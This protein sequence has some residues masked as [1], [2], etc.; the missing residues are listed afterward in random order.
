MYREWTEIQCWLFVMFWNF[1]ILHPRFCTAVWAWVLYVESLWFGVHWILLIFWTTGAW[2]WVINLTILRS[3]PLIDSIQINKKRS[4]QVSIFHVKKIY[5]VA[6]ILQNLLI[7]GHCLIMVAV[8]VISI[9]LITLF[10]F[11][12]FTTVIFVEQTMQIDQ[13]DLMMDNLNKM[14]IMGRESI[15]L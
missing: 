6:R 4:C 10:S 1:I 7:L 3:N 9:V 14:K 5:L 13:D 11:L 8:P 2:P 12:F 15:S